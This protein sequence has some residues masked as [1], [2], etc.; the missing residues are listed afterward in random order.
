MTKKAERKLIHDEESWRKAEP[1]RGKLEE[2]CLDTRKAE[3]KLNQLE[4]S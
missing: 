2:S 4:E 1:A 3:R